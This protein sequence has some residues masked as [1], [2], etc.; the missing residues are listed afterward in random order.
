[1][2]ESFE[3]FWDKSKTQKGSSKN[4]K[5]FFLK[6]D[7]RRAFFFSTFQNVVDINHTILQDSFN[8]SNGQSDD[9]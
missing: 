2:C 4:F 6:F 5:I 9:Q 1:M 3:I 8:K 7:F